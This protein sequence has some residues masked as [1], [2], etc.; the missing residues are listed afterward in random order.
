MKIVNYY[1]EIGSVEQMGMDPLSL[2]PVAGE[3]IG[4]IT[5]ENQDYLITRTTLAFNDDPDYLD[6]ITVKPVI[7]EYVSGSLPNIY[8]DM[9]FDIKAKG[10][11]EVLNEKDKTERI[12]SKALEK[13]INRKYDEAIKEGSMTISKKG[14]NDEI[15]FDEEIKVVAIEHNI[16]EK[17][18]ENISKLENGNKAY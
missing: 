1:N 3:L 13:I 10:M 14:E 7:V 2:G 6:K 11:E 9:E 16:F 12:T 17:K 18:K 4:I 5:K 8:I 15:V